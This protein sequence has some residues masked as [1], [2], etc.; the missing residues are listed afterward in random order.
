MVLFGSIRRF[1]IAAFTLLLFVCFPATVMHAQSS[2]N[3]SQSKEFAEL[4]KGAIAALNADKL[5]DAI[6]LFQKALALNPKWAEGWWS[7]GTSYY[8]QNRYAEASLAFEKV[9]ALDPKHGTAHA[10][11]GLCLFQMGDDAGALKNIEESK[12]FGTDIDPQLRDVVFYHE[13]VLLQRKGYFVAAQKPFAS[14]CLGGNRSSQLL[15]AFGMA[16]LHM[17]NREFPA[18]GSEARQVVSLVG[19]GACLAAYK[20][21]DSA[22]EVFL[23]AV[24]EFPNFP[25][26]HFA[27]GR[28]LIDAREI[29]A[30]IEQ[31]KMEAQSAGPADRVQS[32]LQI[33]AAD[34]KVNSADGLSFVR[35]A[36]AMDPNPP[37]P[38]FL[39]G[40][41]LMDTGAYQAAVSEL[42]IARK[43][44]PSDSKVLWA[45]SSAYGHVG[46]MQDAARTRAEFARLS[47]KESQQAA[48]DNPEVPVETTGG[49][50]KQ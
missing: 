18:P 6:P 28:E 30:A 12:E 44:M 26:V 13:G 16:V 4:S 17:R 45:L 14:L 32:L 34:Y 49:A 29:P 15:A 41:L 8:D 46:R 1:M 22:K 47:E 39:L 31:F 40:L 38:H 7:L 27:Y 33:A 21:F 24:T 5:D 11:L 50:P 23:Q 20:D 36:I 48:S 9:V 19:K 37:F 3:R 43:G 35:Q 2:P 42:E 25:F 10:L